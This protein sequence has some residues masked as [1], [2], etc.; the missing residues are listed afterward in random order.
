MT[1][2]HAN[3][4]RDAL[5]RLESMVPWPSVNMPEKSVRQQ[6]ASA[7]SVVVQVCA[8]DGTRKVVNIPITGLE[9]SSSACTTFQLCQ[10]RQSAD[11]EFWVLFSPAVFVQ[12]PRPV[13]YCCILLPAELFERSVESIEYAAR[14]QRSVAICC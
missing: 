5:S 4:A 13:A 9:E 1:T 3:T 14:I 7:I 11:E 6:I 12:V 2:I 8:E 10:E